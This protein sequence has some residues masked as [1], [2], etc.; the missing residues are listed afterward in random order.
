MCKRVGIIKEGKIIAVE[1]IDSLR[2]KQLRRIQIE[3]LHAAEEEKFACPGMLSP[4]LRGNELNFM[5]AGKIEDLIAALR[6]VKVL[7][8]LIEEPTLEEIFLHYYDDEMEGE[9]EPRVQ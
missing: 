2:K 5:Y 3:F 9:T 1:D 7:D 4:K 8:L 6:S